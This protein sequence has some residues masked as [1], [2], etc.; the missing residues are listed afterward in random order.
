MTKAE[1]AEKLAARAM[2]GVLAALADCRAGRIS[3]DEMDV[4]IVAH[5]D[6]GTGTIAAMVSPLPLGRA[7]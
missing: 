2:T 7:A 3:F 1:V 6:A 4:R 5:A